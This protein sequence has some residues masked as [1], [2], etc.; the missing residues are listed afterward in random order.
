M[1]A[2]ALGNQYRRP[3]FDT[4]DNY[5]A[6]TGG[7]GSYDHKAVEPV[8]NMQD[9]VLEL[10]A[11]K[12]FGALDAVPFRAP[13]EAS[14]ALF[15]GMPYADLA[16]RVRV[17]IR[18]SDPP[19]TRT[20]RI[21][22]VYR[23]KGRGL[24]AADIPHTLFG[25]RSTKKELPW[26]Q[27]A[28]GIGGKTT[29]RNA[30][31]VIVVS[32]PAPETLKSND[33]DQ[34][35]VAVL[36]WEF[37]GKTPTASYLVAS[38]WSGPGDSAPVFSVPAGAAPSFEPGVHLAL[39]SYGVEH[40]H[41]GNFAD[42]RS[43]YTLLN[44][45]LFEPVVP[46]GLDHFNRDFQNLRGLRKRLED[47]PGNPPRKT[48]QETLPF[49]AGGRTYHLPIRYYVFSGRGEPGE[50]RRF[51]APGHVVV[52]TSN[53]Q[54]HHQWSQAEFRD[55]I[56]SLQ[57]LADRVFVVVETDELPIELRST[58]FTADRSAMMRTEQALRLEAEVAGFIR[59]WEDL[60]E[61]RGEL[62]RKALSDGQTEKATVN[63]AKELGRAFK[64]LGFGGG[65]VQAGSNGSSK[66]DGRASRGLGTGVGTGTRRGGPPSNKID[67][68]PDPTILE[69]PEAVVAT[70][71]ESKGIY[72]HINAYDNFIPNRGTLRVSS[73][74]EEIGDREVTI[75]A[76]SKGRL[77]VSVAVPE[78]INVDA[79]ALE[80]TLEPWVKVSGGLGP[81]MNWTT[82]IDIASALPG[83]KGD[84]HQGRGRGKTASAKSGT[85][86]GSG[87]GDIVPIIW[88]NTELEPD[89]TAQTVGQ[90]EE[91]AASDLAAAQP[92]Y[93]PD[94]AAL[95]RAEI[96]VLALNTDFTPYKRYIGA[97]VREATDK[98]RV[99]RQNRYAMSVG[100]GL[101]SLNQR[102]KGLKKRGVAVAD[103]VLDITQQAVAL[104]VLTDLR[105]YDKLAEETGVDQMP[106]GVAAQTSSSE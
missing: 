42:E 27:G 101:L 55:K 66:D 48:A 102:I 73:D 76:L 17:E 50:R 52:F 79:V 41:V 80:I 2:R 38:P 63:L 15:A 8:T 40:I 7:P 77:R 56:P 103:E 67:L 72:F 57:R 104:A 18:E 96:T 86:E 3:L 34:I 65:G 95:G 54:T 83:V 19:A 78:D 47:N 89:W 12:R 31:A 6:V 71:G 70:A 69:G 81:Q 87:V 105:A 26:Q 68:Y 21:T 97:T 44:T 62:V 20:K 53:G 49:N 58:L 33:Q 92:Q 9:S 85:A 84:F 28:F 14:R 59:D 1:I 30:T 13:L 4:P 61:L 90:V 16:Q 37:K 98:T 82:R 74:C 39:I 106:N 51:A 24:S 32:R 100:M 46:I 88:K 45:R 5:G 94:V 64:G 22:I 93:A 91:I 75:G 35:A 29:Y 36:D 23:D 43:F 11:L 10:E 99:T 60:R 25:L